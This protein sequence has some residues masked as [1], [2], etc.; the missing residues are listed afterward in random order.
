M[1]LANLLLILI[2]F[3]FAACNNPKDDTEYL[4]QQTTDE[5]QNETGQQA[6]TGTVTNSRPSYDN[7]RETITRQD[8]NKPPKIEQIKVEMVSSNPRDGF[9]AV[10]SAI[11]P[12]GD[13]V[14]FIYQWKYNGE[15]I[16]GETDQ[17]LTWQEEF[18]KGN[19][20]SIE[21]I[22]YDYDVEGIWKSEGSFV[23]PNSPPLIESNPPGELSEGQLLYTIEASDPDGDSITFNINDAPEGMS[24][25]EM[26]QT[27]EWNVEDAEPGNYRIEINVSDNEGATTTQI[28]DV[29]VEQSD[30]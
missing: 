21:V 4:E 3:V 26:T 19:Q 25:D 8:V 15:D 16:I 5:T 18:E 10:V 1:K 24:F 2:L 27:I 29:S 7:Y 12:E 6:D 13:D 9:R 22:P 28:L 30:S 20:I 23:I 17:I 14:D 11:D